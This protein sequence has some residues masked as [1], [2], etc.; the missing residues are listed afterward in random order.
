M[1]VQVLR[2]R[3]SEVQ[4]LRLRLSEDSVRIGEVRSS[5]L[6]SLWASCAFELR[7]LAND[8]DE[9]YSIQAVQSAEYPIYVSPPTTL[10]L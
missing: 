5:V 9:R 1:E 6:E 7:Y 10:W 4:V 3:L 2:L 8:D